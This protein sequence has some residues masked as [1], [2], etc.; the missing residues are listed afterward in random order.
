[1]I[2]RC[3]NIESPFAG[4]VEEN[5]RY[6]RACMQD[7]LLRGEAPFASHALYT[8]EGVLDDEVPEQRRLGMDAGFEINARLDATVVYTD[9]GMSTGMEE[10]IQRA[11]DDQRTVEYRT[12]LCW[13]L[14][15]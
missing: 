5:V 10:G 8:L 2:M 4:N 14:K 3:V 9:L 6:L 12:L 11:L 13:N 1:M 15:D 7:C